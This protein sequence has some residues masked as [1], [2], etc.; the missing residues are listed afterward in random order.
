MT[1][2]KAVGV[3][4]AAAALVP[5]SA[6]GAPPTIVREN[7]EFTFVDRNLSDACGVMVTGHV[8]G[9][10]TVRTREGGG[11]LE[12]RTVNATGIV[13]SEFGSF[14]VKDVGSE[15]TRL[16]PDGQLIISL[17]GQTPFFFKGVVKLDAAT[18]ELL[19]KPNFAAG[20]RQIERACARLN[21]EN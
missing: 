13:S 15:S 2:A 7:F 19:N 21:P 9:R 12:V 10:F 8:T 1:R 3:L 14:R 20:E 11:V 17:R 6:A 16:T 4:C 5:A 18:G